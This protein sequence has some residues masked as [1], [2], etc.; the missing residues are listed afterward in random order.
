MINIPSYKMC[1]E[2]IYLIYKYKK[3][4]ALN[5]LQRLIYHKTKLSQTK[6]NKT[7]PINGMSGIF[8]E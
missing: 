2:I 5:N 8:H 1:L 3:P 7:K 6:H 4:L